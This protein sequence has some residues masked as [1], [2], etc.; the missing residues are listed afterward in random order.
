MYGADCFLSDGQSIVS[1]ACYD[2]TTSN[3]H[4]H[5]AGCKANQEKAAA[6]VASGSQAVGSTYTPQRLRALLSLWF[7]SGSRPYALVEDVGFRDILYMLNPSVVIP[8]PHTISRDVKEIYWFA[9]Q[10]LAAF[11]KVS[12]IFVAI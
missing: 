4:A 11:F 7:A 2:T 6:P 1:R 8:S 5:I 10:N 9:R 12:E 3:L